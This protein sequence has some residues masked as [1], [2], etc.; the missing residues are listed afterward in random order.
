MNTNNTPTVI[1]Q[2]IIEKPVKKVFEIMR[3][4]KLTST[5]RSIDSITPLK[6][7][8]ITEWEWNATN[9]VLNI[10]TKKIIP[11]KSIETIWQDTFVSVD[12]EFNTLADHNTLVTLKA[13]NFK[14]KGIDLLYAMKDKRSLFKIA[15]KN[16]QNHFTQQKNAE[17]ISRL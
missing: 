9:Y 8:E 1:V 7:G 3:N 11:H 12:Y 14:E 10:W 17:G 15:L 13:Y 2:A 16:L 6:E 5:C 4:T